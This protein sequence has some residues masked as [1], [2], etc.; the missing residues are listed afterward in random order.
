MRY[1]KNIILIGAIRHGRE[2]ICGETMKNQLFIER[3]QHFFHHIYIIDTFRWQRRPWILGKI[4]LYLLWAPTSKV[5]IS[6]ST[7]GAYLLIRFLYYFR[8]KQEIYFWVVGGSFH[9]MLERGLIKRK[10][11]YYLKKIL[12]Q[13][14]KMQAVIENNGFSNVMY[15]PNSKP[16]LYLPHY[17]HKNR[18]IFRFVFLSRIAPQK[19]VNYIFD[20]VRKLNELGFQKVFI[21]DFY[22]KVSKNYQEEFFTQINL[23][24]NITYKGL[25][26]LRENE[27]YNIL[28]T[29]DI[30]LFPTYWEGE[31]FPGVILDAYIAGLPVIASDWN[32]NTEVVQSGKT[33]IIVPPHDSNALLE[34]MLSVIKGNIDIKFLSENSRKEAYNYDSRKILS[35]ELLEKIGLV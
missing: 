17:S 12:V 34:A 13:S 20:C 29:Y 14:P 6:S 18:D 8:L 25:L 1:K 19:G 27:G 24:S 5:V 21:V 15:V 31:G 3:F 26:N 4:L 28:S 30:M 2:A 16:I 22:G 9:K 32:F 23:H 35:K 33:G 10:Y 11:L 7:R